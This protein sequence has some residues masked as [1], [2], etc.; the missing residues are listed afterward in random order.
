VNE[1]IVFL[2]GSEKKPYE[3]VVNKV[4]TRQVT[5]YVS[6]PKGATEVA[7]SSGERSR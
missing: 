3:L 6:A 5:G 7:A 2:V 1:P 4:T